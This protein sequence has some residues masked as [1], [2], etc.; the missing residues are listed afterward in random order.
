MN[1]ACPE[2]SSVFRVDP[3]K[4]PAGGVRARCSVC[5]G[6]MRVDSPPTFGDD[7]W[8]P[9][10]PGRSA[11]PAH[12]GR[13]PTPRRVTPLHGSSTAASP[14][15]SPWRTSPLSSTTTP[16]HPAVVGSGMGGTV[17]HGETSTP[18][19][20]VT[21]AS[22]VGTPAGAAPLVA[23]PPRSSTP[24]RGHQ[25]V[26]PPDTSTTDHSRSVE[27]TPGVGHP[28]SSGSG[29]RAAAAGP[30]VPAAPVAGPPVATPP[31]SRF[32]HFPPSPSTPPRRPT[33]PASGLADRAQRPPI[34][35]FLANDP[36]QKAKR[37]AR[38]LVSDIVAYHPQQREQGLREGTL[39]QLFKDEIKKSYE[40]YVEQVGSEFAESTAHFQDALNEILASGRKMF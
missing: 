17:A 37:L 4:V 15:H 6:V 28:G 8:S 12:A 13:Q 30:T 2:C 29:D 23:T 14:S 7:A 40:E 20:G 19:Q 5:G 34:N 3:A 26:F 25:A 39:R 36:N 10:V 16:T 18:S 35:P 24:V 38:A 22:G 33:P 32:G 21:A 9:A 31:A 11:T 27:D 1:V